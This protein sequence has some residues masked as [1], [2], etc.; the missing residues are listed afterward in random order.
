M[1]AIVILG[2]GLIGGAIGALFDDPKKNKLGV[3]GMQTAG[4]TRFLSFLRNV[5]FKE[6]AAGRVAYNEFKY[7]LKNNKE[8]TILAGVDIA[9]GNIFRNNYDEILQSSDV[10]LYFFDINRYLKNELDEDGILYQRSCNSRFEHIYSQIKIS[11]K[12]VIIIAT[13]KDHVSFSENE[14]KFKFDTLIQNGNKAYKEMLQ[15]IHYVNLTSASETKNL[16]EKIFN[17]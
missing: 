3:L 9:G 14:M 15:N 17:S 12:P 2:G 16:I 11:N 5:P 6:Q 4:K 10:I 8:I 7:K 13:H 1:G